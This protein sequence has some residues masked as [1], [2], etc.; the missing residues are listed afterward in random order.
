MEKAELERIVADA[1]EKETAALHEEIKFIKSEKAG[2][3]EKLGI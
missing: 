3:V 2:V 1:I